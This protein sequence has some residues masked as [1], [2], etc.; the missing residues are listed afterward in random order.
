MIIWKVA[1]RAS[2]CKEAYILAVKIKNNL[3]IAAKPYK[4]HGEWTVVVP[5][6]HLKGAREYCEKL[7]GG[8]EEDGK[9]LV[10]TL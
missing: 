6:R 8:K 1:Q 4:S 5:S 2:S 3:G 10:S 9:T 7:E